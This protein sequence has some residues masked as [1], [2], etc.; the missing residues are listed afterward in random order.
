M[1]QYW[2]DN[3][4]LLETPIDFEGEASKNSGGLPVI[5]G[6]E[7]GVYAMNTVV[8]LVKSS[9]R[10]ELTYLTCDVYAST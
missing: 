7:V 9:A 10:P 1:Q 8:R 6:R 5:G 3:N 2:L 4:T